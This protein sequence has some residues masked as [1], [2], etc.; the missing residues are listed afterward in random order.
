[1]GLIIILNGAAFVLAVGVPII[2][3]LSAPLRLS[4]HRGSELSRSIK[5]AINV[6]RRH[7]LSE[8]LGKDWLLAT[9]RLGRPTDRMKHA[10][11]W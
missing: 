7:V 3:T 9:Q 1:M 5:R 11:L 2:P 8:R 6:A 10:P 4:S